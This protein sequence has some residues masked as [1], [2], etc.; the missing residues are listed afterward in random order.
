MP[1]SVSRSADPAP[2]SQTAD[3]AY[4]QLK[5][6]I[7]RGSHTPGG[8]LVMNDLKARYGLGVGPLREALTRLVGERLVTTVSQ[9]GYRVAP[10]SLEALET[11][12]DARAEL[13][14]LLVRLAIERGDDDWE[15]DIVAS[16]HR[17]SKIQRL[18]SAEQ[19]L[20]LWDTRHQ[21]FHDA[22]VAGCGCE[23]LLQARAALFDQAQR[24]RYLWLRDTVFSDDALADKR[25][26]HD[27]LVE[28]VLERRAELACRQVRAHLLTPVPIIRERLGATHL[29]Q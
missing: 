20:T 5:R 11:I 10:L 12:Y 9:R 15:A 6:D 4:R 1:I 23:P 18:K 29:D 3:D 21:A 25:A 24:Y 28:A 2:A 8:K 13:E 7:V 14:A 17:L 27:A 22:I 19:T 16:A 26:E